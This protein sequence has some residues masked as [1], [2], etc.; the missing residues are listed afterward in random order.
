M[1]PKEQNDWQGE[2]C[3]EMNILQNSTREK[4]CD[5]TLT[6]HETKE[7]KQIIDNRDNTPEDRAILGQDRGGSSNAWSFLEEH[8]I[9]DADNCPSPLDLAKRH[10]KWATDWKRMDDEKLTGAKRDKCKRKPQ[11]TI[12]GCKIFLL[13]ATNPSNNKKQKKYVYTCLDDCKF[14]AP[15]QEALKPLTT[16]SGLSPIG[17][18]YVH[19]E[20]YMT[21]WTL[22]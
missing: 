16:E 17:W 13:R 7:S 22:T 5:S 4:L 14:K 10:K 12:E 6:E 15:D 18:V 1:S 8:P 19:K 3:T 9:Y 20:I 21:N 11:D 2:C